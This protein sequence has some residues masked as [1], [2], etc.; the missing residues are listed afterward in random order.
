MPTPHEPTV[1]KILKDRGRDVTL[2][3]ALED[4]FETVK[5]N[6]DKRWWRRKTT[7][8]ELVWEH[9][10]ENAAAAFADDPGIRVVHHHDTVSFLIDDAVL[11]R[12]KKAN[13]QLQTRNYPTQ[14]ALQFHEHDVDLFGHPGMQR[15]EAVYVP[16]R[17]ETDIDWIG[18][19][20][21]DQNSILWQFELGA[22]EASDVVTLPASLPVGPAADRVLKIKETGAGDGAAQNN[23]A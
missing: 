7:T 18:I 16:N 17:F 2:R 6:P 22:D 3:R 8:A 12:I 19:V 9:T 20:A 14:Q 21:N 13:L 4:A 11:V 15:V 5:A 1:R 23:N 10:V